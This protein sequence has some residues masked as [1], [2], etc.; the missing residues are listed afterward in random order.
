MWSG[1]EP[2]EGIVNKTYIDI[3]KELVTKYGKEGIYTIL[4]MHQDVLW[5]AG[6]L[7]D[8]G[9]WGIPKWIKTKLNPPKNLFPWPF[10]NIP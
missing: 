2:M 3:L 5:K 9:Y 1:V 7:E 6:P 10:T 8:H 4:D